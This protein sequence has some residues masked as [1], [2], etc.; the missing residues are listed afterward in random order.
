MFKLSVF[1][2]RPTFYSLATSFSLQILPQTLFYFIHKIPPRS[3]KTLLLPVSISITWKLVGWAKTFF[4]RYWGWRFF[5]PTLYTSLTVLGS[6]TFSFIL[7]VAFLWWRKRSWRWLCCSGGSRG[8]RLDETFGYDLLITV[9]SISHR[10]WT[11]ESFLPS[12][13]ETAC[14]CSRT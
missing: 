7:F 3:P 2:V 4:E 9:W 11:V 14:V 8:S 5:F 6:F 1:Q 13:F 10:P 12:C